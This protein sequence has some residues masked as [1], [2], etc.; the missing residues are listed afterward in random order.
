MNKVVKA[1]NEKVAALD[2][3]DAIE[4]QADGTKRAENKKEAGIRQAKILAAEG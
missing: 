3:A 4:R 2:F 1:N